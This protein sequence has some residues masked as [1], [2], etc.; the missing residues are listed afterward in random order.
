MTYIAATSAAFSKQLI[1]HS[2]ANVASSPA[3]NARRVQE[4]IHQWHDAVVQRLNTLVKLERGWDGYNGVPV[5][6]ENAHF[7]MNMLF[8]ACLLDTPAP[9]IVPGSNGDLQVEWHTEKGDIELHVQ[10]PYKVEAWRSSETTGIDGEEI[11]LTSNF[12]VVAKWIAEISEPI[13]ASRS[14]AA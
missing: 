5:S 3:F 10:A 2:G 8:S 11:S 13:V 7:A 1:E 9:Q 12:A 6:F 4:P 14:A